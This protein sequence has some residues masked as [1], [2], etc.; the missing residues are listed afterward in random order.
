MKKAEYAVSQSSGEDDLIAVVGVSLHE[1][2]QDAVAMAADPGFLGIAPAEAALLDPC[3]WSTLE[4][5][6]TA[7]EHAGIVPD[8]LRGTRTAV[9]L[10]A[11]ASDDLAERVCAVLGLTGPS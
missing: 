6:W 10:S 5:G 2:P 11:A 1:R 4:L 8:S 3:H 9:F 7:L